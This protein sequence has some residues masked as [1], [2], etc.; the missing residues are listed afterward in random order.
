MRIAIGLLTVLSACITAHA[1]LRVFS[2]PGADGT[3]QEVQQGPLTE[4]RFLQVI[5]FD[6]FTDGIIP[7]R[8]QDIISVPAIDLDLEPIEYS[9]DD[10]DSL[11][12]F[13]RH[14]AAVDVVALERVE[15]D[16]G[17]VEVGD[18]LIPRLSGF[19]RGVAEVQLL[20]RAGISEIPALL[21]VA[22]SHPRPPVGDKFNKS[23]NLTTFGIFE[24]SMTD[25]RLQGFLA[26]MF[27]NDPRTSFPR[28]DEV[29]QDVRQKWI[30]Y[31]DLGRFFP[32]RLMRFYPRPDSGLRLSSFT[33]F[34]GVPG[35]EKEIA[36]ISL[37]DPRL[38]SEGFPEFTNIARTFPTFVERENRPVNLDDT[39][40]V[41]FDPPQKLR[42]SRIDFRSDLDYDM[43]E[44]EFFADGY[45]PEAAYLT[46]PLAL[47]PATLGRIFWDEE[48]IGDPLRSQAVV[49]VQT[50]L[51]AEPLVLFRV[52]D[53][54]N[55]VEWKRDE[56]GGAFVIDRRPGSQTFEQEVDLNSAQFN[57]DAR[58]IFSALSDDE[59]AAVR[60]TRAEYQSLPGNQRRQTEADPVFWSG[61]QPVESGELISSPSGR[62]FIQIEIDFLSDDPDA[63]TV[64]RNLR[65]EFSSPQITQEVVGEIAPAVDVIAG[66]DTTFVLALR[67][68]LSDENDG[69]NRLQ[70]FTPA[71]VESIEGVSLDLGDGQEII[72]ER[73]AIDAVQGEAAEGQF[74]EVH[75]TDNQFVIGFPAIKPENL[76]A[77]EALLRV[78]FVGRVVDFR[79]NF[80]GNAFLDTLGE[81]GAR[82]FT[83]NGILVRDE[84]SADTLALF[85]PQPLAEEN[86][87]DFETAERLEDR[88]SLSVVA[89]I[90]Q[91]SKS[92]ITNLRV[93]PNP[94]TPNGDGVNDQL[95]VFYDIQRLLAPRTVKVEIYDLSGRPLRSFER[96]LKSGGYSQTWDGR[97]EEGNALT[98]GLYLLRLSTNADDAGAAEVQVIS[99][100]Y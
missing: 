23:L 47:P 37:D 9:A 84:A 24:Q 21:N 59:R 7:V 86:V 20:R 85:L 95:N 14:I 55:E 76:Q 70:I 19:P 62:P 18:I 96:Q 27:D 5:D 64:I 36:G 73:I 46:I 66:Q 68:A 42:Y 31:M 30:L 6:S 97:D 41:F 91:Q 28:I 29:G 43:A 87:I 44:F 78:R 89:D 48:K 53:F 75:I 40:A 3:W 92:L 16:E 51:N 22:E 32:I 33:F 35:T 38:G 8:P 56:E 34:T 39:V 15:L 93:F 58:E 80:G 81:T 61:F 79:T 10:P 99:I 45:V 50:G 52:D 100:A 11:F 25:D 12:A 90:S 71:R 4:N 72:L 67:A 1:E 82:E 98:P 83:T 94:F 74:K 13:S 63:A 88:N 54:E 26:N 69:F 77:E 49:R 2:L 17:S 65:F 57:L 60:L